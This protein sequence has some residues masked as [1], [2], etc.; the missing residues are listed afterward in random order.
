MYSLYPTFQLLEHEE[1]LLS[2]KG[3]LE[4]D[5]I[6]YLIS[7]LEKGAKKEEGNDKTFRKM[8]GVFIEA[9]QNAFHYAEPGPNETKSTL[10]LV[11]KNT[12]AYQIQTGN[13]IGVDKIAP[14][15]KYVNEL[16]KLNALELKERY[17]EKLKNG[18]FSSKGTAGLGMIDMLRKSGNTIAFHVEPMNAVYAFLSLQLTIQIDEY[19]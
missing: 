16:N 13:Y 9:I 6:Q 1:I 5:T 19:E 4:P 8:L 12:T 3:K 2:F 11:R 18:I 17:K 14:F 15:E 10:V 7:I